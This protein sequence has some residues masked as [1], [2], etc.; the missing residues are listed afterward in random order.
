MLTSPIKRE[1]RNVEVSRR[2]RA[3]KAKKSTKKRD[4]RAKLLFPKINLVPRASFRWLCG[5]EVALIFKR[6]HH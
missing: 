5:D 6:R 3:E 4:A 1:T 2:S